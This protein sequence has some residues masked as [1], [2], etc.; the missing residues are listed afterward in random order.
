MKVVEM[1]AS[2]GSA[3]DSLPVT[4]EPAKLKAYFSKRPGAVLQRIFQVLSPGG[5][6]IEKHLKPNRRV[7]FL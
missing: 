6:R 3:E 5:S 2:D 4:Y 1:R 7:F